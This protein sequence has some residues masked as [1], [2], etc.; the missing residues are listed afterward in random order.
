[1][2][3]EDSTDLTNRRLAMQQR[4]MGTRVGRNE[5]GYQ[6]WA[7]EAKRGNSKMI[8]RFQAWITGSHLF[9]RDTLEEELIWKRNQELYFGY[10]NVEMFR[11]YPSIHVTQVIGHIRLMIRGKV[12]YESLHNYSFLFNSNNVGLL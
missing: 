8:C 7:G 3:F 5:T 2:Y 9:Q 11:R 4:K 1:M 6:G 10:V 12:Q